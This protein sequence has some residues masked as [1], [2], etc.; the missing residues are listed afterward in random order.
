MADTVR[1]DPRGVERGF[2]LLEVLVAFA[3]LSVALGGLLLV[4]S[5]G[6]RTA[7]RSVTISTATLQAQSLLAEV[8]R[9]IPA[10][11]GLVDGVLEDGSRWE[12]AIEPFDTGESGTSTAVARL[13]AYR[14]DVTVA[15]DRD[16]SVTLTSLRL[17]PDDR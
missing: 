14:V 2:T 15:W 6:L 3:I 4:F 10:R 8:G 5:D 17:A 9:T 16:R 11:A 12:V 7:D 1:S 13:Y